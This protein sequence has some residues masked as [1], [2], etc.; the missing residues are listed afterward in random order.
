MKA[1][2]VQNSGVKHTGTSKGWLTALRFTG[3]NAAV[4]G[5]SSCHLHLSSCIAT[6]MCEDQ[7]TSWNSR[8]L[9]HTA[10]LAVSPRPSF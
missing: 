5:L 4:Y 10:L 1:W 7:T 2:R 6:M 3:G 9:P 8:G